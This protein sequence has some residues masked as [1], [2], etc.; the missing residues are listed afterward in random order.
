MTEEAYR[1]KLRKDEIEHL[2]NH[3]PKVPMPDADKHRNKAY[4]RGANSKIDIQ[5]VDNDGEGNKGKNANRT[6]L[7]N[8]HNTLIIERVEGDMVIQRG[9]EYT[10]RISKG[11]FRNGKVVGISQ[12]KKTVTM[13]FKRNDGTTYKSEFDGAS[14]YPKGYDGVYNKKNFNGDTAR[15]GSN[16]PN[17]K[18]SVDPLEIRETLKKL[19]LEGENLLNND[20]ITSKQYEDIIA[21]IDAVNV[22]D[23]DSDDSMSLRRLKR[24]LKRDMMR[25]KEAVMVD[26]RTAAIRTAKN[27]PELAKAVKEFDKTGFEF[28]SESDLQAAIDRN[29]GYKIRSFIYEDIEK[30]GLKDTL[31]GFTTDVTVDQLEKFKKELQNKY[32]NMPEAKREVNDI[33]R[34]IDRSIL[35]ITLDEQRKKKEEQRKR[36]LE[37]QRKKE[38]EAKKALEKPIEYKDTELGRKIKEIVSSSDVSVER[39][40]KIG[41]VVG[42]ALENRTAELYGEGYAEADRKFK[43][44]A[45]L[46]RELH[47][48]ELQLEEAMKKMYDKR[49]KPEK[50]EEW[51]SKR[52]E[53]EVLKKE[54]DT[55]MKTA[56]RDMAEY[57]RKLNTVKEKAYLSVMNE[58]REM[59]GELT[60][61]TSSS[62]KKETFIA[63]RY[64][65]DI[66]KLYP[67]EW[68]Q[69]V[70]SK[71]FKVKHTGGRAYVQG[72][73]IN[74]NGTED[75]YD[76]NRSTYLHELQH[77][78]DDSNQ[79]LKKLTKDLYIAL[80][81]KGK[82]K[83]IYDG[84]SEEYRTK[85]DG[86]PW[87]HNYMGKLY[88]VYGKTPEGTVA[89]EMNTMAMEMIVTG[90]HEWEG[91]RLQDLEKEVYYHMLGVLASV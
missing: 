25:S 41:K 28:Y 35:R 4:F 36:E 65:N 84:T 55:K 86:S 79:N 52:A 69:A 57:H 12:A 58:I 89:W 14:I 50:R 61:N 13:E 29:V 39:T 82:V 17:G 53:L 19:E 70:T 77:A 51:K 45:D 1:E 91:V 43:E 64:K 44:M 26:E 21:R 38:E 71:G 87:L 3:P 2:K 7:T 5:P 72:Y 88:S 30:A 62:S 85:N 66:A 34:S 47:K 46:K 67:K 18:K 11:V 37:E 81:N 74:V 23:D 59:G 49:L 42:E 80:T 56:G 78:M 6:D 73:S 27:L 20:H 90:R 76:T 54:L 24:S 16:S 31:R 22:P 8:D 63:G 40:A 15:K 68:L 75:Y 83:K 48:C 60:L 9:G 32:G 10:A 33:F